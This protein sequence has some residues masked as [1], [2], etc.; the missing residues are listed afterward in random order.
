MPVCVSGEGQGDEEKWE[1]KKSHY[2]EMG[3]QVKKKIEKHQ[4]K[5]QLKTPFNN[6][7]HLLDLTGS[8]PMLFFVCMCGRSSTRTNDRFPVI[9]T[10]FPRKGFVD[11]YLELKFS[12]EGQL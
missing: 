2:L 3:L 6:S 4:L 10:K 9:T 8:C 12:V 11:P 7:A 5:N 1:K